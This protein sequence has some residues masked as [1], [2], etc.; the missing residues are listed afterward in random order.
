MKLIFYVSTMSQYILNVMVADYCS[1]F[2]VN[3]LQMCMV[4]VNGD[5]IFLANISKKYT[6]YTNLG[7]A[8]PVSCK[9]T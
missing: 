5:F 8:L 7:L 2:S 6:K 3:M 1:I 4:G 9:W